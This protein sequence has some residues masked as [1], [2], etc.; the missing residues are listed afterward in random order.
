MFRAR[1][2]GRQAGGGHFP[3]P[4]T[5]PT[6]LAGSTENIPP[7]DAAVVREPSSKGRSLF[8]P[9]TGLGAHFPNQIHDPASPQEDTI[10]PCRDSQKGKQRADTQ[11]EQ[12]RQWHG[13]LLDRQQQPSSPRYQFALEG[14]DS[15]RNQSTLDIVESEVGL[16]MQLHQEEQNKK[17]TKFIETVPVQTVPRASSPPRSVE[18]QDPSLH[19]RAIQNRHRYSKV[20][21][22]YIRC[23]Q[24]IAEVG[25]GIERLS[26]LGYTKNPFPAE[27]S[28][29]HNF[30][31][32]LEQEGLLSSDEMKR[33]ADILRNLNSREF[34]ILNA[35]PCSSKETT[36]PKLKTLPDQPRRIE[37]VHGKRT[38]EELEKEEEEP[39]ILSEDEEDTETPE[40]ETDTHETAPEQFWQYNVYRTELGDNTDPEPVFLS[41]H[42]SKRRAQTVMKEQIQA[43][44]GDLSARTRLEFHVT[45]EEDFE[46]QSLTLASGR[47]VILRIER[48]LIER[49]T[50]KKNRRLKLQSLPTTIYTVTEQV[51][52]FEPEPEPQ[53]GEEDDLFVGA[54]QEATSSTTYTEMKEC[55][56]LRR[57]ANRQAS[58]LMLAHLTAHLDGEEKFDLE[59]TGNIDT[60]EEKYLV[61]L[62]DGDRLY[63][64][65]EVL[66]MDGEG[67]RKEV[68]IRVVEHLV[69]G[70]RN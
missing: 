59:R 28:Q 12:N 32:K 58:Q 9:P 24:R 29:Y 41:S 70:P 66:A 63:D 4:G 19:S 3:L 40:A 67:Q 20:G 50:R 23:A 7:D 37:K 11:D 22:A 55:F 44:Y 8:R 18:N 61:E 51:T 65:R 64:K 34:K 45:I 47:T 54:A 15:S 13:R 42:L 16:Q 36:G 35:Q 25:D 57:D 53:T 26:A 69:R 27:I 46:E 30:K 52:S 2:V 68:L 62:E 6:S 49:Q 14:S 48:E 17:R 56:V 5:V 21:R 33:L 60:E 10:A 43:S 1:K 31:R 39:V 38:I